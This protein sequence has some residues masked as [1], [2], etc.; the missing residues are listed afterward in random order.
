MDKNL[1]KLLCNL[2]PEINKKCFEIKEK[3]REKMIQKLFIL[4]SILLLI[5]PSLLIIIGIS[6]FSMLIGIGSFTLIALVIMLPFAIKEERGVC[7]E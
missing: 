4:V 1:E 6:I 5:I 7:Y 3:K 2:E